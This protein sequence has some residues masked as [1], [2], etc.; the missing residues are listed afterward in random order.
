MTPDR[1]QRQLVI[2][3]QVYSVL[4]PTLIQAL[5]GTRVRP[6]FWKPIMEQ[7]I[8]E[9]T[10]IRYEVVTKNCWNQLHSYTCIRLVNP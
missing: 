4:S 5:L 8:K 7:M 3:L 2:L 10:L 6:R 1:L 9:G